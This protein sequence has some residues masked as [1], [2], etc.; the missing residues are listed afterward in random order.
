LGASCSSATRSRRAGLLSSASDTRSL[1]EQ[2][3]RRIQDEVPALAQLKIVFALDLRGRGDVQLYRVALPGPQVTKEPAGDAPV[4]VE[5]VRAR[6][7]DLATQGT[8]RGWRQAFE[9][10]EA[11]ATGPREILR[12]IA[13]VVGKQEERGRTRK[14]RHVD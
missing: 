5:V 13:T 1:I 6:F 12:L 2:A 11:K 14:A 3:V 4:R 7:N 10:G 9:H 8:I